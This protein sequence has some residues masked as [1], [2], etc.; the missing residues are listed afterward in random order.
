[1]KI[2]NVVSTVYLFRAYDT[3]TDWRGPV[4]DTAAEAN[5]DANAHDA[6]LRAAGGYGSAL[7]VTSRNGR[8]VDLAGVYVYP[9]HGRTNGA[10]RWAL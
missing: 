6:D 1:M 9:P 4:R 8:M 3:T 7:V 5:A 2:T 10:A